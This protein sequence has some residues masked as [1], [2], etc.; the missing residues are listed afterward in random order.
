MNGELIY[1]L[2]IKEEIIPSCITHHNEPRIQLKFEC[3]ERLINAVKRLPDRRWSKTLNAWHIPRD[4][5]L[6]EQLITELE[7]KQHMHPIWMN[8]YLRQM[9][10]QHYSYATQKSYRSHLLAFVHYFNDTDV[11]TLTK[12]DIERYLESLCDEKKLSAS[13]MNVAVNAI[14]FLF[15]KVWNRPRAVYQ[16]RR[17]QKEHQL[18]PVFGESEVKKIIDVVENLKHRS[19]L[20]L[21]YAAGLA[22]NSFVLK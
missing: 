19:M 15:E 7:G 22:A 13:A 10:I 16:I 11:A 8:D 20:C 18:P 3:N 6:L 21:A 4:K 9:K 2:L 17:A 12:P 1:Q 5:K 14:K